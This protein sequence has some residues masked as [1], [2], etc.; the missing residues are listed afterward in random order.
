MTRDIEMLICAEC[1]HGHQP[2]VTSCPD[3]TFTDACPYLGLD[4]PPK[5]ERDRVASELDAVYRDCGEW[6]WP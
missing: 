3:H 4:C 2:P 5:A 1:G 6:Y